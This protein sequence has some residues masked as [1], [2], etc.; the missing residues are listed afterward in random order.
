MP[1]FPLLAVDIGN[2]RIKVGLFRR[3]SDEGLPEP[4]RVLPLDGERPPLENIGAWLAE[5]S[6]SVSC[7]SM[8]WFIASVNR[9]AATRLIDWIGTNR[10]EDRV[11]LLS[12]ADLPLEVRLECPDMVGIDRL[13]DAVA[14]NRLRRPNAPAVIVDVGS[15]ITVD[16]L[17][18]D[19]AFLGGSILPGLAMSARAMHKFT[20]LLPLIETADLANPPPALGTCTEEAMRSGLFWGA[21]GAIRQLIEELS[22]YT[23]AP[24]EVFLTGGAGATVAKLLGTNTRHVPH[25]TLAGIALAAE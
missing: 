9:P 13:V 19:G 14:V 8:P 25:L 24:P 22:S 15:A 16:L 3:L 5:I 12:A 20:D 11:T 2:A 23:D 21:V 10:P 1:S 6:P 7:E 18:P 4:E 17:S